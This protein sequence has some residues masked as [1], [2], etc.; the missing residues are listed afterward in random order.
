MSLQK[1]AAALDGEVSGNQVLAPGPGHSHEDRS[2]SVKLDRSAPDGLLVHSHANDDWQTCKDYVK[3]R[4]GIE[5]EWKRKPERRKVLDFNTAKKQ[6]TPPRKAK[7][8]RV[9]ESYDY[10]LA[11]GTPYVRA[12]RYEPKGFRQR[13]W[14]GTAWE[15][16][17]AKGEPIPY[18]LPELKRA[19]HDTVFI[20]EGEKDA[21]NLGKRGFVAT[22]NI[23]GAGN[24]SP[25]LN[26]HFVGKVVYTLP[27]NDEPGAKHA[28]DVARDLHGVAASVRIV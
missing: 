19:V 13:H 20:V 21:D 27:D 18:R 22:T 8:G 25:A 9:V 26:Q 17:G 24:W 15:Y 3:E 6:D 28:V 2:L 23:G 5:G 4:L 11:D 12:V 1:L 10:L 14:T 16:G 7:L